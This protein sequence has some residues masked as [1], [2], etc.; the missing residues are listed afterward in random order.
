[1]AVDIFNLFANS[2]ETVAVKQAVR[3][4]MGVPTGTSV[5]LQAIVKRRNSMAEATNQSE[6]YNNQTTIHFKASDKQ[7]I[8]VGAFAQVDGEWH[9]I[10]QVRDGKNFDTG[11]TEFYKVYLADDIQPTTDDPVWGGGTSV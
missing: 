8:N 4:T 3:G 5:N 6:D 7:Y 9:T 1:M 11:K 2:L 10:E